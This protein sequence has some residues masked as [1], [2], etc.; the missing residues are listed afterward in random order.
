MGVAHPANKEEGTYMRRLTYLLTIV[1]IIAVPGMLHAAMSNYC[2]VP[3]YITR[4]IA[5]N[6][7]ILM[8]NSSDMYNPAY[9]DSYTPTNNYIGYFIPGACYEYSSNKFVE[10]PKTGSISCT[11]AGCYTSYTFP[12]DRANPASGDANNCPSTAPFRG[13]LLNWA[14]TSKYDLLQK[15]LIGGNATSKQGNAHTLVSI[16]GSWTKSYSGT[17]SAGNTFNCTF[18]VASASLNITES[19]SG[20]CLLLDTPNEQIAFLSR[21]WFKDAYAR[22]LKGLDGL[23]SFVSVGVKGFSVFAL[24]AWEKINLVA[25]AWAGGTC[26]IT[27][28]SSLN[29]TV[30]TPYSLVL[31]AVGTTGS[32]DYTW[33]TVMRPGWLIAGPTLNG[34]KN[35]TATWGPNTP[36]TPGSYTLTATVNNAGCSNGPVSTT[37]TIV[38]SAA[39]LII[40]STSPLAAGQLGTAYSV[41]LSGQGGVTPYTWSV[42]SGSLPAGLSLNASTGEISGT[43]TTAG[44]STFTI[45]LSDNYAGN[46]PDPTKSFSISITAS[47]LAI[48]TSS[49]ANG[50][51][52]NAYGPVTMAGSGGVTPYTW[53]LS[54]GS[55]PSGVSMTSA[56]VISGTP[57]GGTQGNYSVTIKLTDNVGIFTTKTFTFTI[58]TSGGQPVIETSSL[59]DAVKSTPYSFTVTGSGGTTPYTWSATGLP[60]SLSINSSTG[61]ISGTPAANEVGSYSIII[62]L[63]DNNGTVVTKTLGLTVL[64]SS[65]TRSSSFNVKVDLVE[66]TFTDSNGNDV[67]CDTT[68]EQ[69]SFVDFNGNGQ[70][71]GKGGIFQQFWDE[72]KPKARW[73]LTK[74]GS[75]GTVDIDSCIPASP[76]SSFYTRIQNASPTDSSPLA[77]GLYGDIN[78]YGFNSTNFSGYVSGQYSGC[79]NSDPIDNV[80]CRKNFILVI[81]SGSDVTGSNFSDTSCTD[82]TPHNHDSEPLVQNGCYGYKHDLRDSPTADTKPGTQNVYTYIVNTMGASATNNQ[83]MED[84]A[85]AGG[86]QYY[87]ASDTSDLE[88]Q[89]RLALTDILAQAASGTAVSVLTTSS[90]GIG[91]M[92]QA[93]FLPSK[94]EGTREVMWTGYLQ[95]LWID[96]KDNLREDTDQQSGDPIKLEMDKDNV[97]KLYFDSASNETKAAT[98]TTDADGNGGTL[99][100][101]SSP[102]IKAFSSVNYLWEAGKKLALRDPTNRT[103]FTSTNILRTSGTSSITTTTT[104]IVTNA[105]TL[106]SITGDITG[107]KTDCSGLSGETLTK[108]NALD[109]DTSGDTD[110]AYA[111][112]VS[113][114]VRYVQGECLETGVSSGSCGT[115]ANGTYRDRRIDLS[116]GGGASNGNVWKLGDIISST[117][118]VFANTPLNTYH[119]DYGD[120]SYYNYIASTSYKKHSSIAFVGANDGILHAFRVGYL[121]DTGLASGIKALFRNF[122]GSTATDYAAEDASNAKDLIG[123]EVWGYIPFNAFPYLRYLASTG[124]C[125]IY[126]NDLSVRLVDASIGGDTALD[127]NVNGGGT[128][129]TDKR[130]QSNWKTILVGGMRFGGACTTGSGTDASPTPPA[131]VSNTGYSAYY[132]IDITDPENPVPLWEFSDADMGYATTFPSIIRTGAGNTNGYWYAVFGSGSKQLPKTDTDISRTGTGYVYI[133]NLK[134]GELVKK[135]ALD[136]AAIIGDIL[137]IDKEKDYHSEKIYFGT[138]YDSSGWKG[139]LATIEIPNQN[140]ASAWTPAITNLFTGNYPFT[141]SPDAAKDTDGI[142]WVYAGSGKYY[143]D[144]DDSDSSA[145]LFLG[146]KDTASL[147]GYPY[148]TSGLTDRSGS[149]N[150]TIGTITGTSQVCMYDSSPPAGFKFKTIV[151][152]INQTSATITP[153]AVGWYITLPYTGERVITRP[154]AVGG[155]VD[156]LTYVPDTSNPCSYGGNSYLYAV[157]YTTGVAPANVAILAPETTGGVT[158]VGTTGVTVERGVLLGPGAPPTGEAIIIPPPKE[159]QETLKKKIQ[160]ATGVI[161]EAENEP[162]TSVISKVVHWL[163]K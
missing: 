144:V 109:R 108:C 79:N 156:F 62:T 130:I 71:D 27:V 40:N 137:A 145:Q 25:E 50:I 47:S 38:I 86:G 89:L 87:N 35:K 132:A 107:A 153:P 42:D 112:N 53:S 68:S 66:E 118:K 74:F 67:C 13:N 60:S 135:I 100:S 90:R 94:Q 22:F 105:F 56:G 11:T 139:K 26:S 102:T 43:P 121:K 150:N 28:S 163:K 141:A 34:S 158:A 57:A 12:A 20:A 97:L 96:P 128:L 162:V 49:L 78:Y 80:S 8:D 124:Y 126:Y 120:S 134:T 30:G 77:A 159:G 83:I 131:T 72:T 1:L 98:F 69:S 51:I 157:G 152:S 110:K 3:P 18:N 99:A 104:T 64:K 14:T 76:A 123:E 55:W 19:T 114:I 127:G 45:K 61:V 2:S 7:M 46:D 85:K 58:S 6:I 142:T 41:T 33:T 133:V 4:D 23:Y 143:S 148:S 29:G 75:G 119:I 117:P 73:G 10:K 103:L 5:P 149:G 88:A 116:A 161:I 93:Y 31:D 24:T 21:E 48:T 63:T 81:S 70:W 111:A 17:N 154:L 52:N 82:A 16:G 115:T 122:F 113:N 151:T 84:A 39:T 32:A 125:H 146:I 129:P 54:A 147:T 155:L 91:S 95:N 106:G 9:T 37:Q 136:H 101:C 65:T 36:T 138:A 92:V 59:D 160:I 44:T 15:V 140:L